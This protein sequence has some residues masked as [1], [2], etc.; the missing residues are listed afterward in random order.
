VKAHRRTA[1]L[2]A[3]LALAVL[4]PATAGAGTPRASAPL[5]PRDL[6]SLA[7]ASHALLGLERPHAAAAR[8][9]LRR[10]GGVELS[11]RLAIWRVS[12]D[13]AR[14][15]IPRL[16]KAG[17]LREF[18]ADR[19]LSP[20]AAST[21]GGALASFG[22]W[23]SRVGA[24]RAASPTAGVPV[25][26]IDSGLDVT[27]P[28]F[29]DRPH[30]TLLN[31]QTVRGGGT[32]WHGTA[33]SSMIAAPTTGI[34]TAGVYPDA[35]LYSYDASPL[36]QLTVASLVAGLDRAASLGR[37][38]VN[39][40]LGGLLREPLEEHVILEAYDRGL[41]VVAAAGND[42]EDGSPNTFPANFPHV[43]T[44]AATD[45]NDKVAFFSTQSLGVDLAAPG[46]DVPVALPG[47]R[48]GTSS[49]TSFAAPIV[50]G[51]A[52]WL[53]T[54]RPTFD[55]TQVMEALRRS[56]RDI[57]AAG[58][59]ADTGWGMLDIP[60]ALNIA[61]PI[62]DPSE[63]NDDVNQ[64]VTD[65]IFGHAK[66]ALTRPGAPGASFSA[67]LDH[68]EDS[69]DVYRVWVP[70]RQRVTVTLTSDSDVDLELWR[71][72]TRSVHD[73]GWLRRQSLASAGRQG[74]GTKTVSTVNRGRAGAYYYV[75]AYLRDGL[76]AV[77]ASYSLSVS[78][79][80]KVSK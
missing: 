38:V 52:A 4:A 60:G 72:G 74:P 17:W 62:A 56:A 28:A 53:W 80:I 18:Q 19:V 49:G 71:P 27:H 10:A 41:V 32:E 40:S 14:R 51:A 79:P 34:G 39:L 26:V 8:P 15:L 64:V 46:H 69:E 33:V 22:W 6:S 13:G 57:G 78:N 9:L 36:G 43:L 3:G 21:A 76:P 16:A 35:N 29:R 24:D 68:I 5:V 7:T 73:R 44:V 25:T 54:V 47:A 11:H 37:G 77:G 67:R 75:D 65:G 20:A 31:E 12:R 50:S 55:K 1:A 48:W 70:R 30:T 45:V 61:A 2:T 66:P 23:Y 58:R 59:D 63:P 42:R